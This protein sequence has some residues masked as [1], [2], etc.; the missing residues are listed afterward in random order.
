MKI[1]LCFLF[2]TVLL[3][4]GCGKAVNRK[5]SAI[6]YKAGTYSTSTKG[7]GG[8]LTIEVN[9]SNNSILSVKVTEHNE[10]EWIGDQA[11]ASL[12]DNITKEQRWNVD[13]VAGAT[14][15]SEAIKTAVRD[16]IR[17]ATVK[18]EEGK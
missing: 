2:L 8:D 11:I 14:I 17:Q 5:N 18:N 7:Y 6:I 15:T 3:T 13:T 10:T 12:P 4:A 1:R 16:C 9:F